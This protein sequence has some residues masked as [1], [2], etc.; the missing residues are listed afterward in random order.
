MGVKHPFSPF[1]FDLVPMKIPSHHCQDETQ[2]I[3]WFVTPLS[4]REEQV[5]EASWLSKIALKRFF[6]T[7][8]DKD[9]DGRFWFRFRNLTPALTCL[10]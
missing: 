8:F 1:P 9:S 10:F 6:F 7:M 3:P 4:P 2:W 5:L